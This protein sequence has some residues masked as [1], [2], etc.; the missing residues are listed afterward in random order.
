MLVPV[1]GGGLVSGIATAVKGRARTRASSPSSPSARARCTPALAA[2]EPV[3]VEPTSIADG[4]N[5]PVRR[6]ELRRGLPR[7]RGRERAR[8]RGGDRGRIPLP[9]RAREARLRAAG[10]AR[11]RRSA[12]RQGRARVGAGRRVA[13]VSGGN[14]AA[15]NGRLLSWPGD[16]G[17]HPSRVRARDRALLLRQHVPDPL[18]EARAPRRDLLEVPPVLHGQAEADG[19]GRPRRALPAPARAGRRPP[20]AAKPL[21]H[22]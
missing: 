20:A 14:V 15:R 5:G 4:L 2:G 8:H 9:L 19:H 13:V 16:E 10:A 18:D 22:G 17:R 12:R 21:R 6:R 1:G 11:S 7:A 3:T